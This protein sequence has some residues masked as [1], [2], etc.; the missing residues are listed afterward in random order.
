MTKDILSAALDKACE[1]PS[2]GTEQ[3][4]GLKGIILTLLTCD[5][6]TIVLGMDGVVAKSMTLDTV[7]SADFPTCQPPTE[8]AN[9]GSH[10]TSMWLPGEAQNFDCDSNDDGKVDASDGDLNNLIGMAAGIAPD[11]DI[12]ATLAENIAEGDLIFLPAIKDYTGGDATDLEM[13]F[14]IGA[15]PQPGFPD[16]CNDVPVD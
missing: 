16:Q 1:T 10:V 4:C 13:V 11:F 3:L 9:A 12:N 5:D 6:C 8:L 15:I 7:D 2:E 14:Y